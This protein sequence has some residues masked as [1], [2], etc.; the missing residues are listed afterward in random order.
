MPTYPDQAPIDDPRIEVLRTN[1]KGQTFEF[2][3]AVYT[4]S[5][6]QGW[7]YIEAWMVG[8]PAK[9]SKDLRLE[10]AS[11]D[12]VEMVCIDLRRMLERAEEFARIGSLGQLGDITYDEEDGTPE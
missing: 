11:I 9:F 10:I 3:G 7:Y 8:E 5:L 4:D 2:E 12:V 1:S 6:G